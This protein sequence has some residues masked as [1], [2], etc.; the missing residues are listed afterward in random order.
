MKEEGKEEE[1]VLTTTAVLVKILKRHSGRV[2]RVGGQTEK[3]LDGMSELDP[4]LYF[5]P[6]G[7]P[8]DKAYLR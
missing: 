1:E 2:G 4:E 5:K 6:E 7:L 8:I 3:N